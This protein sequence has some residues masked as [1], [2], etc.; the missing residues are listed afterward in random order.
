MNDL[1]EL[2]G[3]SDGVTFNLDEVEDW[4]AVLSRF[5]SIIEERSKVFT[6]SSIALNFG[7]REV[8]RDDLETMQQLLGDHTITLAEVLSKKSGKRSMLP[9]CWISEPTRRTK[10]RFRRW[11][12]SP[13]T[14]S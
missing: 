3:R 9:F 7:G 13:L 8:S 6:G 4:D 1:I 10:S 12:T 11:K 5:V 14:P 2:K